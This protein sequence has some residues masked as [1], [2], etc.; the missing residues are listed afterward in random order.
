MDHLLGQIADA[1]VMSKLDANSGYYQIVLDP[2]SRELTTF[3]IPLRRF[4]FIR[5]IFGITSACEI[6]QKCMSRLVEGIPGV[7]CLIDDILVF[8]KSQEE[9]DERLHQVFTKLKTAGVTLNQSKCEF[10]KSSLTFLVHIIS[11]DGLKPEP[12]KIQSI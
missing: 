8:G 11:T 2:E 10:S 3:I 6:Y 7:L 12:Q 1:K 4:C 9:H 5:L